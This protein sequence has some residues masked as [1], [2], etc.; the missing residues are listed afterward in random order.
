MPLPPVQVSLWVLML[1]LEEPVLPL[2]CIDA[3]SFISTLPLPP[4]PCRFSSPTSR[5]RAVTPAGLACS[6][7]NLPC[8]TRVL[9]PELGL[10]VSD[11]SAL[12][13]A[14][15]FSSA[16]AANVG[17]GAVMRLLLVEEDFAFSCLCGLSQSCA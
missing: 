11:A 14:S 2:G 7:W 5:S 6:P 12:S 9:P 4:T 1:L 17:S 3:S 16:R 15:F 10:S 13:L 8:P